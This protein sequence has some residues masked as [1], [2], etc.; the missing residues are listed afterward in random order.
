MSRPPTAAFGL[1]DAG[2]HRDSPAHE[3]L[4]LG[5]RRAAVDD[6]VQPELCRV[7]SLGVVTGEPDEANPAFVARVEKLG[8]QGSA[9]GADDDDVG[10]EHVEALEQ[11]APAHE[12]GDDRV[13]VLDEVGHQP[14]F[15]RGIERERE[16]RHVSRPPIAQR[17]GR[18]HRRRRAPGAGRRPSRAGRAARPT[19]PQTAPCPRSRRDRR[20][21]RRRSAPSAVRRH[22]VR[23]PSQTR[24]RCD[25]PPRAPSA[26]ARDWARRR[27]TARCD[28]PRRPPTS[29]RTRRRRPCGSR[30]ARRPADSSASR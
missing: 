17:R 10:R 30:R 24:R 20:S 26:P 16:P 6:L 8:A 28:R 18:S 13:P 9:T 27:P 15:G 21:R 25:H 12:A 29:A 5:G 19:P 2:G 14:V 7:R 11:V 3:R 23:R 4:D 1:A 22:P